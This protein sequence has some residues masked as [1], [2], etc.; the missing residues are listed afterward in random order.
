MDDD[1]KNA[2]EINTN[3]SDEELRAH[4]T[5]NVKAELETA[6][7]KPLKPVEFGEKL[8]KPKNSSKTTII[9]VVVLVLLVVGAAAFFF[10]FNQD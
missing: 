9:L 10:I 1:K 2:A 7:E 3:L 5:V 8:D 4:Q 6:S